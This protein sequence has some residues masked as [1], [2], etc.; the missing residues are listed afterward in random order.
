MRWN[1]FL[2]NL[3][4]MATLLKCVYLIRNPMFGHIDIQLSIFFLPVFSLHFKLCFCH[5]HLYNSTVCLQCA[6]DYLLCYSNNVWYGVCLCAFELFILA[7]LGFISVAFVL[8]M[9]ELI[10]CVQQSH[11]PTTMSNWMNVIQIA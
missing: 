1:D 9:R 6:W 7:Y 3:Q 5:F 10:S 2:S 4:S 11:I 8:W